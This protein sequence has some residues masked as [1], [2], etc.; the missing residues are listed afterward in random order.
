MRF[1]FLFPSLFLACSGGEQEPSTKQTPKKTTPT[2]IAKPKTIDSDHP[3]AKVYTEVCQACHMLSGKG[4][5]KSYPPLVGSE[6]LNKSD[7]I[8]IRILLHGL[9][10][11]ITVAGKEYGSMSM[12]NNNLNDTQIADVISFIRSYYGKIEKP[13]SEAQVK[14]VRGLYPDGHPAWRLETLKPFE[15]GAISS[16]GKKSVDPDKATKTSKGK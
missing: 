2:Q 12:A 13:V 11:K 4:L 14:A 9:E 6:W 10:G 16:E 3:G 15:S 1:H 5:G 8:L 7:D